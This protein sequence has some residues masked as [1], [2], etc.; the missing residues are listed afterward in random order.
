MESTQSFGIEETAIRFAALDG[1]D[2]GGV[3]YSARG[4]ASPNAAV[5][6]ACG[7]GIPAVRYANFATY[8]AREGV[9]VLAFDYRGIGM[10]RPTKLRGFRATLEDWSEYDCAGAIAQLAAR[11]GTG[12]LV[13]IA[14]SIGAFLIGGAPN[15]AHL[16]RFVFIGAHTGYFGDYQRRF[17][18]PMALLWHGVM[19]TLARTVGYF[20]GRRLRLGDDIP[21]EVALQW[22]RRR[23]ANP[24]TVQAG[25]DDPSRWTAFFRR[26]T[27]ATGPALVLGFKDDA[28]A[29]AAGTNR[30]LKEFPHIQVS[31]LEIA[32]KDVGL[33]R[34]GHFGFFRRSSESSLWPLVLEYARSGVVPT[35]E[36]GTVS[37]GPRR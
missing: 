9:A 25:S 22:A 13:G 27:S 34:I 30:F 8:L 18:W 16:R 6:L 31:R 33:R 35:L 20:P 4:L 19:P 15:L 7:G 37:D 28:F 29:T 3:I 21:R 17:R 11:Y 10:S 36:S 23:H 1:F 2:L 26:C 5:V 12:A 24:R 14:H 32:P